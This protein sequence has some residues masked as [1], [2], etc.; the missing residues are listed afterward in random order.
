MHQSFPSFV[1][2]TLSL[3]LTNSI[4]HSVSQSLT[5]SLTHSLTQSLYTS[6]TH[7][8]LIHSITYSLTSSLT[9]SLTH[10]LSNSQALTR[11]SR[12]SPSHPLPILTY[13]RTY[14]TQSLANSLKQSV[15]HSIIYFFA[16]LHNHSV[17]PLCNNPYP[18]LSLTVTHTL[19][20]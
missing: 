11:Q 15:F 2:H 7:F 14:S 18:I 12:F 5:H 6:T 16:C 3:S 13:L 10:S 4:S 9:T 1:S 8:T 20:L 19:S 17:S